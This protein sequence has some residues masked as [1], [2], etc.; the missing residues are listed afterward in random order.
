MLV[1]V[2]EQL[3]GL[4]GMPGAAQSLDGAIAFERERPALGECERELCRVCKI[5]FVVDS[6]PVPRI[7]AKVTHQHGN[8]GDEPACGLKLDDG[9][10]N[11]GVGVFL[12]QRSFQLCDETESGTIVLSGYQNRDDLCADFRQAQL[13]ESVRL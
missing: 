2:A 10:E 12:I 1:K 11:E 8:G 4:R 5:P 6:L 13:V 3:G 7:P 9:A